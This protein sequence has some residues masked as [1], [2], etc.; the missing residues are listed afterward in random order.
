MNPI[1]R[2]TDDS[3]FV[4]PDTPMR[5]GASLMLEA[6]AA[7]QKKSLE[8][9]GDGSKQ[10]LTF[11]VDVDRHEALVGLEED[12]EIGQEKTIG[13]IESTKIN[14]EEERL[15]LSNL[16]LRLDSLEDQS[17]QLNLISTQKP[18]IP[19]EKITEQPDTI[20][21]IKQFARNVLTWGRYVRESNKKLTGLTDQL[22]AFEKELV[23]L[24]DR[25]N[26]YPSDMKFSDYDETQDFKQDVLG[27]EEFE[28]IEMLDI[29][30]KPD[31]G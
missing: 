11:W 14:I 13:L 28:G 2:K 4:A 18:S 6:M 17:R 30:D 22:Q 3:T 27:E 21:V 5:S 26:S 25:I 31:L 24:E 23:Q 10:V 15:K 9:L 20:E 7:N 29:S 12:P 19:E 16:I 1:K 8:K